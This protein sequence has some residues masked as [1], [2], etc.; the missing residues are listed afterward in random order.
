MK[1]ESTG[2]NETR[3]TTP[4]RGSAPLWLVVASFAAVYTIWGSTYLGIRY[5]VE[6][7]PPFLMAGS[8][9]LMAGIALF[10]FARLRG[11]AAPTR[12]EWRDAA[13]AGTL[14]L[15]I[16]NGG[17]TW[18]EQRIPSSIAALLVALTPLWM[19]L[20]DWLRPGGVRPRTLVGVGLVFGIAGVALLA[21]GNGEHH[22]AI[23]GWSVAALLAASVGWAFGSMFSRG[24]RKPASPFLG[25]SMQMIA[26]GSVLF[27][28]AATQG[29]FGQFSLAR[30]TALSFGSWLFLV[31]AGSLVA[32]TAYVW[33]LQVS[34]PAR[35]ATYAYVNPLIAVLLGCTLGREVFS[36]ALVLAGVLIIVAVAL[37]VRGGAK[38]APKNIQPVNE[39]SA[40]L[41]VPE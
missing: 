33:L 14:M 12:T 24:A 28:L 39:P 6:S 10:T 32:Y 17:V 20:I 13:I 26:G 16:G 23:Y 3:R 8:R 27:G 7:I 1:T 35:V 15:V 5:A 37:I 41:S 18:A 11:A 22:E 30:V 36:H 21:R 38:P 4:A 31:I 19:V 34:T 29:E 2:P 9:H 25:V 40:A